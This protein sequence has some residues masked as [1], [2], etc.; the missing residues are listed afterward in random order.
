MSVKY[1]QFIPRALIVFALLSGVFLVSPPCFAGDAVIL[2]PEED[3]DVPEGS[4]IPEERSKE[5]E[6]KVKEYKDQMRKE[7]LQE[8]Q[9]LRQEESPKAG[10]TQ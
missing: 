3:R 7:Y 8:Q 6:E 1:S 2:V 4:Q 5:I 9:R 10:G